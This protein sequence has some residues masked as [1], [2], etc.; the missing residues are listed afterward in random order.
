MTDRTLK[1]AV[2]LVALATV[3]A[4]TPAQAGK[5]LDAVRQR[6]HLLC[7]VSTGVAGFSA[8]D[9]QGQ[10][11]GLDVDICKAVA[12]A[13]LGQPD[14]VKYVPLNAQQRFVA[15]Q[16]G[17][18]DVL[19][20]NTSWTISRDTSLGLHFTAVTYFDGQAFIVPARLKLQTAR[21]L[22]QAQVCVQAGTTSEKN[23][24]DFSRTHK[25]GIKPVVFD[26]YEGAFKA[27]FSGRC[28]AFSADASALSS[29]RNKE[30]PKPADHVV[31]PDL[32]S[33]EP[34]GP[35]VRRGDDDWL[36]IVRWTVFALQEAEELGVTQSS[37]L[38]SAQSGDSAA[39]RLL[40]G[41]ED[42]GKAMGLDKAWAL[43]AVQAVGNYGEL[44]ERNVGRQSPLR[45]PRGPNRPWTQGGLMYAP[46]LR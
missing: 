10:W 33:K 29:V 31:L 38:Q 15:L 2:A 19:S 41:S 11:R 23:L 18:I 45:L 46:P 40:G 13:T 14:K 32:I 22:R 16:S 6:G 39:Q 30:A 4:A 5:T 25:L 35:M 12:A 43:R 34:L 37:A 44:F 3:L 7:G 17:Q 24:A 9:D 1:P 21:Q 26:S 8:A 27:Y 20:R 28:Q 42:L 36:A